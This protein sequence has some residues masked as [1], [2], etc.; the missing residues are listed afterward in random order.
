MK[1]KKTVLISML[2]LCTLL[3][4][5]FAT[6]CEPKDNISDSTENNVDNNS[7]ANKDE[8]SSSGNETVTITYYDT[9]DGETI[10][11]KMVENFNNDS[12][13]VKVDLQII[14]NDSYDDK[15]Q[16]LLSGGSKVDVFYIRTPGQ[17]NEFAQNGALADITEMV[18]NSDLDLANYGNLLESIKINDRYYSLPRS[19]SG[20]MLFYN[21]DIFD[22]EGIEYPG[23][24]TWDEY[25]DIAKKLTK[26]EGNDK[27]WGG[28]YP[29]WI[30]NI[31]A[32]QA[33]EYLID[34]DLTQTQKSLELLNRMYNTD[35]SH[36]SVAD[37]TAT[38]SNPVPEFESGNV[39]LL[40]QGDWTIAMLN[41]DEEAGKSDVNWD[42]APMPVFDDVEAGTTAGGFSTVGISA[43]SKN[44]EESFKFI[45]YFCGAEGADIMASVACCPAYA[46][47]AGADIYIK[48]TG[49]ESAKTLFES[50]IV[51]EQPAHPK[52]N[53]ILESFTQNAELYLLGEKSIE[54]TMDTF[55]SERE[56]ILAE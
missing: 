44:I 49:K 29:T 5:V 36:M 34:D 53:K 16:V 25:A 18:A 2:L 40:P 19:K 51:L 38:S 35:N 41:E 22:K 26:G 3:I 11:N 31:M 20:W 14:P 21:K 47:D 8:D 54:E 33:D 55:K 9:S 4:G 13:D 1:N 56:N 7:T 42:I 24:M 28:Y 17:A 6:G 52:Y 23:Q 50:K 15:V 39:A 48:A 12:E 10:A 43:N 27:Q 45:E 32:I 37:M 30:M 46:T